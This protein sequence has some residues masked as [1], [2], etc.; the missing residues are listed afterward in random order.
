MPSIS[1][2]HKYVTIVQ[3]VVNS[4]CLISPILVA[5]ITYIPSEVLFEIIN[6]QTLMCPNIIKNAYSVRVL[7]IF[8]KT[9]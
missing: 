6:I 9:D 1:I 4:V 5:S 2:M 8:P 7:C 3:S